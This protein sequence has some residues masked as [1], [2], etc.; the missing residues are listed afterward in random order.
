M[1]E[2]E[3]V[4]KFIKRT[5]DEDGNLRPGLPGF[6]AYGW[7]TC[8]IQMLGTEPR[9]LEEIHGAHLEY[10]RQWDREGYGYTLADIMEGL[11]HLIRLGMVVPI[12]SSE[13]ET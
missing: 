6:C 3:G 8:E 2:K 5:H 7:P 10:D 1:S 11:A 12:Y 9:T 13:K 4:M